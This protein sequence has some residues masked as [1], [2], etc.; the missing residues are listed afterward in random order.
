MEYELRVHTY[1]V[2]E[3][4][5]TWF[6]GDT[7]IGEHTGY[8]LVTIHDDGRKTI[9]SI[10]L[11]SVNKGTTIIP[12]LYVIFNFNTSNAELMAVPNSNGEGYKNVYVP[13][14][15]TAE[16]IEK[17]HYATHDEILTGD[18][19]LKVF[20]QIKLE[21]LILDQF[22]QYIEYELL[23]R[24]CNTST[25]YFADKY[26]NGI[27]VFAGLPTATYR[28]RE[29]DFVDG[30]EYVMRAGDLASSL[31]DY[32]PEDF[33]FDLINMDIVDDGVSI[34]D[35]HYNYRMEFKTTQ[36][37]IFNEKDG[38]FIVTGNE[39]TSVNNRVNSSVIIS[40]TG[41]DYISVSG[42]YNKVNSGANADTIYI[43][44][45]HNVAN[46]GSGDDI[47]N[48]EGDQNTVN[49]GA[50]NDTINVGSF[51]NK[52]DNN[53]INGGAGDD[54]IILCG[55][56][57][58]IEWNVGGG[59]DT[60]QTGRN[61]EDNSGN[62]VR[63]GVGITFDDVI[64]QYVNGQYQ[65]MFTGDPNSGVSLASEIKN[66]QFEEENQTI[67][68]DSGLILTQKDISEEIVGT[69]GNDIIYGNKGDDNIQGGEGDDTYVWD[70]GDGLDTITDY[71]GINRIRFGAGISEDD[72]KIYAIGA[73]AK[74]VI[75]NDPTQGMIVKNFLSEENYRFKEFVFADG[76]V[77]DLANV[78]AIYQVTAPNM[79]TTA[80]KYDD[81]MYGSSG[82][83]TLRGVEGD[84]ELHGG[85]GDDTLYGGEGND[86]LYGGDGND[87][88]YGENGDDVLWG[89]AGDDFLR[90]DEGNNTY[91]W[92]LG[93]GLDTIANGDAY[94][95]NSA[96]GVTTVEFGEGITFDNLKFKSSYESLFVCVNND[97]TQ[98]VILSEYRDAQHPVYLKF[99]DGTIKNIST[100]GLT[101]YQKDEY[102]SVYG[103]NHD[104][105]IYM[106]GK[107][108]YVYGMGGNDIIYGGAGNDEIRATKFDTAYNDPNDNSQLYGGAGND[109]LMGGDGNDILEGGTGDDGLHGGKGDDTYVYNLGDGSDF[110]FDEGGNNDKIKFGAGITFDD[111]TIS[112]ATW[113]PY[114]TTVYIDINKTDSRLEVYDQLT[115][116]G[117]IETLEFADGSQVSL[118]SI[119]DQF[120]QAMSTFGVDHSATSDIAGTVGENAADMYNLA[121]S[122]GLYKK[123]A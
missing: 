39:S 58:V 9:Q 81:I 77:K 14:G 51:F 93:D 49:G 115:E 52:S 118:K 48:I 117:T 100:M 57:N 25:K 66:I 71:Q 102:N 75:K 16:D 32:L 44:G 7:F 62:M 18:E 34:T 80:S 27:D 98:G 43:Y 123:A 109:M 89:G 110:I 30:N 95:S 83:D 24:N 97:D 94:N 20:N 104:D 31:A 42:N 56:N 19:A 79:T 68:I 61:G 107:G 47:I 106:G 105:V 65:V 23:G 55:D 60:I 54:T 26:L 17:L 78:G 64:Y 74:I 46:A 86:I 11:S 73:D 40:G 113:S 82:N 108:G 50:G 33:N 120:I 92:N 87:T 21:A 101:I 111:L 70:L 3:D 114:S 15:T 63:L 53:T 90:G 119:T 91:L 72:V 22:S 38:A 10:D 121:A 122:D 103:S 59:F 28:G 12:D 67:N 13:A 76:H 41:A 8:D 99:K 1:D 2:R 84:D 29:K 88:L 85:E 45:E 5:L 112:K 35:G 4:L 37:S 36:T 96:V 6:P 116:T 69:K